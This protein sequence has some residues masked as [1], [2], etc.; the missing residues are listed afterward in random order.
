MMPRQLQIY[1]AEFIEQEAN[2]IAERVFSYYNLEKGI[3]KVD[4]TIMLKKLKP[5]LKWR[6]N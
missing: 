3:S 5:R 6:W 2:D 1:T 4:L